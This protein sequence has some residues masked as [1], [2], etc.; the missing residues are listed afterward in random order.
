MDLENKYKTLSRRSIYRRQLVSFLMLGTAKEQPHPFY[1]LSMDDATL[2]AKAL[3]YAS[4]IFYSRPFLLYVIGVILDKDSFSVTVFDRAG[5]L[6]SERRAFSANLDLFVRVIR[7]LSHDMSL[8]DL[9]HNPNMYLSPGHTY[10]QTAYPSFVVETGGVSS[11]CQRFL[12]EGKPIFIS[13]SLMGRGA[14]V[15]NIYYGEQ[16]AMLAVAWRM[17]SISGNSGSGGSSSSSQLGRGTCLVA[18]DFLWSDHDLPL[19]IE[20]VRKCK[21]KDRN[22]L[23]LQYLVITPAGKMLWEAN[24]DM[25]LVSG[26]LA[27]IQGYIAMPNKDTTSLGILPDNIY[28]WDERRNRTPVPLEMEGFIVG[29]DS[30]SSN[31]SRDS[32]V[33]TQTQMQSTMECSILS[34]MRESPFEAA[35]ALKP[36]ARSIHHD[37]ESF[38]LVFLYTLARRALTQH[39]KNE[40]VRDTFHDVFICT[41][42]SKLRRQR[43]LLWSGAFACVGR[44]HGEVVAALAS[45]LIEL[46][47]A[48]NQ[49]LNDEFRKPPVFLDLQGSKFL[50]PPESK[51]ISWELVEDLFVRAKR[52]LG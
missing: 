3:A 36:I 24:S 29:P 52:V 26:F 11:G 45:I 14:S 30:E 17:E 51:P 22:N 28:L 5:M 48:Q 32:L 23:V 35:L 4:R 44:C 20:S 13:M 49:V 40:Q 39:P 12:T 18:G 43:K 37:M 46:M 38:I 42:L 9:G 21:L 16:P 15:W 27:V 33:A 34:S 8:V 1:G 25:E 50:N 10:H 19:D 2:D 31:E 7:R 41:D 6:S 47:S